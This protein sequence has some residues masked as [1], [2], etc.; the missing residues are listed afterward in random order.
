MTLQRHMF[1]NYDDETITIEIKAYETV[2]IYKLEPEGSTTETLVD[3]Q[4][5]PQNEQCV[6]FELHIP[7]GMIYGLGVYSTPEYTNPDTAHLTILTMS[8]KDPWP[9]PPP[10]P[11][12]YDR[13]GYATRC[14][15]FL[16]GL[17]GERE[18]Q[19]APDPGPSVELAAG[20]R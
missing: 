2:D 4:E 7:A 16:S 11:P 9:Q 1:V 17:G 12:P 10:P 19:Q 6:I 15:S 20:T 14:A 18:L 8:G 13:T 5:V 3:T